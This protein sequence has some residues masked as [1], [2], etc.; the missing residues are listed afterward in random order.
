M[1][2][3]ALRNERTGDVVVSRLLV[4]DTFFRRFRG[5]QFA[6]GLEEGSGLLLVRCASIHTFWMR[7][8]IDVL[9]LSSSGEV[10]QINQCVRPWRC[11]VGR[12]KPHAVLEIASGASSNTIEVGDYVRLV[13]GESSNLAESLEFLRSDGEQ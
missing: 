5:L 8:A 6:R 13:A 4:A 12:K 11:V 9:F 2:Q 7:F 10:L 3:L 1:S